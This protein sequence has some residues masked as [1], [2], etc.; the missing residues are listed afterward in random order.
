MLGL[1]TEMYELSEFYSDKPE[2]SDRFLCKVLAAGAISIYLDILN[3]GDLS[4]AASGLSKE[5]ST[6]RVIQLFNTF[7]AQCSG[8]KTKDPGEVDLFGD[9]IGLNGV[10]VDD[11]LIQA[12]KER[13]RLLFTAFQERFKVRDCVDILGFD[14]FRY[15]EYDEETQ[16]EIES[17]EWMKKCTECMQYSITT[18]AK[19]R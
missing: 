18:I 19:T 15:D 17:G 2:D 7:L 6:R 11:A 14:P 12:F 13:T 16:G 4:T 9:D 8:E 1:P 3:R 10:V 5:Q